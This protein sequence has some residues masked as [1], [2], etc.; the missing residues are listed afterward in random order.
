[1]SNEMILRHVIVDSNERKDKEK[2]GRVK[3]SRKERKKEMKVVAS[4]RNERLEVPRIPTKANWN[5]NHG[6]VVSKWNKRERERD[7]T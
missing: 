7:G 4:V 3:V 1:M 5:R 2:E 6:H